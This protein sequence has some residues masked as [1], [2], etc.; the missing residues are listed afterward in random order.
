[1]LPTPEMHHLA[2]FDEDD[3]PPGAGLAGAFAA[4]DDEDDEQRVGQLVQEIFSF[5]DSTISNWV[6]EVRRCLARFLHH[7]HFSFVAIHATI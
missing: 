6:V 3:S 1:M 2:P 7:S 5:R 4:C